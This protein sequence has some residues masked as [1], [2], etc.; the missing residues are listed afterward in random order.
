LDV[1]FPGDRSP[2]ALPFVDDFAWRTFV[3]INWP[4]APGR[5]GVPDRSKRLGEP[6]EAVVWGTWKA[7]HELFQP[8]GAA[9]SAWDA[10]DAASPDPSLARA[11]AG[12]VKVLG[13]FRRR[14]GPGPE[15]EHYNQAGFGSAIGALAGRNREYVR[16]EIV[17]NRVA[18]DFVRERGYHRASALPA[19]RQVLFP[20]GAIHVK[21]AWRRFTKEEQADAALLA[22][23]YTARARLVEPDG[24]RTE[25]VIG[26][27]GLHVVARTPTS[28]EWI[29]TSFEHVDNVEGASAFSDP[30]ATEEPNAL[31]PEVTADAPP[32]PHPAP[33]RVV[34]RKAIHPSTAATNRAW[35]EH[36]EV[37]GTVW[38]NYQLVLSQ[39]PTDPAPSDEALDARFAGRY[40][41]GSGL[42][43]PDRD[44]PTST[45][46]VV[47]ETD[48]HVQT[49]SSCLHCHWRAG[50]A[51]RT[52]FVW[53]LGLRA[54]RPSEDER[55]AEARRLR[56]F[57]TKMLSEE[58]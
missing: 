49:A 52:G 42:P 37:R 31:L 16:Y 23:H 21:A 54:W 26:L 22:R 41:A 19:G 1:E 14:G 13:G 55:V 20:E 33:V 50:R 56:A 29:W 40:P 6:A 25:D 2:T 45:A 7:D 36:P 5:R 24:R 47:L 28:R 15:I 9:P 44:S 51:V 48:D 30:R 35:R 43:F 8:G 58:R 53:M 10:F 12:R 11:D 57:S 34:R 38:S 46:N 18:Y 32:V 17:V 39:W 3:A 27:V 4:A